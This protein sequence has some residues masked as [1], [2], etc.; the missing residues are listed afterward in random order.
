MGWAYSVS[1][2]AEEAGREGGRGRRRE[3]GERE[4]GDGGR[5]RGRGRVRMRVRRRERGGGGR[6]EKRIMIES[7]LR[8]ASQQKCYG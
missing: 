4:G 8:P 1:P 2:L 7:S 3:R 6:G 5:E